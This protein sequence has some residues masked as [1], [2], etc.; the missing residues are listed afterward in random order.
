M[1][2]KI[3]AAA[4]VIAVLLAAALPDMMKE[5][6]RAAACTVQVTAVLDPDYRKTISTYKGSSD[7][8]SYEYT[9]G[10]ELY[11]FYDRVKSGRTPKDKLV[12]LTDPA[13]P[14]SAVLKGGR[15]AD[16]I[17]CR[18]VLTGVLTLAEVLMIRSFIRKKKEKTI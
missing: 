9:C 18:L 12:I 1:K 5:Y 13:D 11:F 6:K 4:L 16:V 10:D 14:Q 2:A 15:Y 17:D 7:E 3:V 8:Y